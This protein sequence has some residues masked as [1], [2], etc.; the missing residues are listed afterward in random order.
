MYTNC[1]LFQH[2]GFCTNF[3]LESKNYLKTYNFKMRSLCISFL[4]WSLYGTQQSI[5]GSIHKDS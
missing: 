1:W 2:L 4:C 5:G 3:K